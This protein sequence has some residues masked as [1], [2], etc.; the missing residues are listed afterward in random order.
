MRT[1]T[2]PANL[3][4]L[5]MIFA[6]IACCTGLCVSENKQHEHQVQEFY[7]KHGRIARVIDIYGDR[8]EDKF[9]N[10]ITRAVLETPDG[11]RLVYSYV[12]N[13]VVPLINE[14]YKM[15]VRS[16]GCYRGVNHYRLESIERVK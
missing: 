9:R 14:T 13:Y 8:T 10:P 16:N 12:D 15:N 11:T 4:A 1:N 7:E 2:L 5:S 3:L 6:P